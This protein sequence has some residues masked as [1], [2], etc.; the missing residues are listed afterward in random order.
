[1]LEELQKDKLIQGG[2]AQESEPEFQS[3]D[4]PGIWVNDSQSQLNPTRVRHLCRPNSID[5]IAR[6]VDFA[7]KSQCAVSTSGGKHAMGGQQFGDGNMQLDMSDFNRIIRLDSAKGLV[8]VEAGIKWPKLTR[9]LHRLQQDQTSDIE[10]WV[11]KEKQTGVDS[12]SI[13]G[14]LSANM[15]GCLLYTSPSPRDKRQS[16]MPSSA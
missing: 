3:R 2:W 16:R 1:M 14:S 13:G 15:H 4:C 12:V 9:D 7:N 10:P 8:V 6:L 11:I 5:E